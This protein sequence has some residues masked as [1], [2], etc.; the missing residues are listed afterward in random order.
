MHNEKTIK[1]VNE[2]Y[3]K[4]ISKF[5][6]K[7][8]NEQ[9]AEDCLQHI[10]FKLCKKEYNI[11]SPRSFINGAMPMVFFNYK[12]SNKRYF[13]SDELVS[14]W[15]DGEKALGF[16]GLLPVFQPTVENDIDN[17]QI[18]EIIYNEIG[19]LPPQQRDAVLRRMR[20]EHE[21]TNTEKANFRHGMLKLKKSLTSIENVDMMSL[22]N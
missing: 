4:I 11:N 2:N 15:D 13:F 22:Y 3:K 8:C 14:D 20:D 17:H 9:A 19:K 7:F 6:N 18:L 21:N 5:S 10:L 1:Y 16:L 12:R